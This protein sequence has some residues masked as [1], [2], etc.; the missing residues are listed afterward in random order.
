MLPYSVPPFEGKVNQVVF[1]DLEA[2]VSK[3]GANRWEQ[4][5]LSWRG[6]GEDFSPAAEAG[7]PIRYNGEKHTYMVSPGLMDTWR[8]P[9]KELRISFPRGRGTEG[10]RLSR[11]E[12]AR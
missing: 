1:L 5:M 8:R 10:Y 11:I 2:K 6:E 9:I 12:V 3:G 4:G 7:F